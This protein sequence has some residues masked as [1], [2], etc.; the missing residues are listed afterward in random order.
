MVKFI[1]SM[2]VISYYRS[3]DVAPTLL[4]RFAKFNFWNFISILFIF[5][6]VF[7]TSI[8]LIYVIN[9]FDTLYITMSYIAIIIFWIKNRT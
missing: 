9:P 8:P 7:E 1:A 4:F 5:V 3:D 2:C 6:I